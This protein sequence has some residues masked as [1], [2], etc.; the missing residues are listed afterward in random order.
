MPEPVRRFLAWLRSPEFL[1]TSAS[2]AF[3]A[4][5]SLPPMVLL[6]FWVAG[7]VVD[8][9]ALQDLGTQVDDQAPDQL[10]VADVL[11][12]LIDVAA[13]TGPVAAVAAVWPA[14]TYGAALARAFSAVA[15]ETERRIRG[16][17]G[18]LLALAIIAV[19]PLAVFSALAALYLV[20]RL[21]GS[22][23]ALR[24]AMGLGALLLLCLGI[25]LVY[26]L[27]RLWETRVGD[28]VIG[29]ATATGLVAVTTG[30]YLVYLEHADFTARYGPTALA[31]AVLLGLWLLLGNAA[32]IAG[33]RVLARRVHAR[34]RATGAAG[35]V[36]PR[37]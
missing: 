37:A 9:S 19:L 11:R 10:P 29:A 33:Y 15:P 4:M 24:L 23:L 30:G 8:D 28:V 17:T 22:G 6:G 3:Y 20:P 26:T 36:V 1:T 7:L 34:R 27:F 13:Q 5:V 12:A 16:W 14:T 32:L 21:L 25:G 31:T 18:R 2:L 35:T